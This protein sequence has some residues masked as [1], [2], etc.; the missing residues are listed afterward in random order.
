MRLAY[1]KGHLS[2]KNLNPFQHWALLY[3]LYLNR[4]TEVEDIQA[5]LIQQTYNLFPERWGDL[6]RSHVLNELGIADE[7]AEDVVVDDLDEL[8]KFYEQMEKKQ[9]IRGGNLP[10]AFTPQRG[11]RV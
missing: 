8:N 10:D 6:Y 5:E 4:R 9:W 11:V 3:W 2:Q 1:E 7:A